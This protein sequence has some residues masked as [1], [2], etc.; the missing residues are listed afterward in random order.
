[1]DEGKEQKRAEAIAAMMAGF[2]SVRCWS[3]LR[4][5]LTR[6][7]QG[8]ISE[9][10]QEIRASLARLDDAVNS[11]QSLSSDDISTLRRQL[12]Q[13]SLAVL[14]QTNRSQQLADESEIVVR[15]NDELQTR[16]TALEADYEDLLDKTIQED[17]RVNTDMSARV[18]DIKVRL[19]GASRDPAL[20]GSARPSLKPNMR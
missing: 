4:R 1:M 12:E 20:T 17:E 9:K 10:E 3:H 16:V 15:R 13:S 5:R 14:E 18:L 6:T 8:A 2:E 7:G 11:N 19:I